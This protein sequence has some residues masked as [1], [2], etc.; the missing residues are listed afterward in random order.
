VDCVFD[1]HV[2]FIPC[3]NATYLFELIPLR[4]RGQSWEVGCSN[5][6]EL[7][8]LMTTAMR[9]INQPTHVQNNFDSCFTRRALYFLIININFS[10]SRNGYKFC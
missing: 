5:G 6:I 4:G 8:N 7:T 9:M 10:A 3:V 1:R 2:I